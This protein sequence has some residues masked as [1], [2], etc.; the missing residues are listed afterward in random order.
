MVYNS[1]VATVTNFSRV[2][3]LKTKTVAVNKKNDGDDQ[4]ERKRRK[5]KKKN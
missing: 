2:G 3:K 4:L 1:V 5:T